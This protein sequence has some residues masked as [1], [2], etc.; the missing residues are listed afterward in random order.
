MLTPHGHSET[1]KNSENQQPREFENALEF[2]KQASS[3]IRRQL[4][5]NLFDLSSGWELFTMRPKIEIRLPKIDIIH[6]VPTEIALK[7]FKYL[8]ARSLVACNQVS[9]HWNSISYDSSLWH[10]KCHHDFPQKFNKYCI[11]CDALANRVAQM[12]LK[13]D[14]Q[15]W[16]NI[17]AEKYGIERNWK[18]G[19]FT[20][21]KFNDI[22]K[23]IYCFQVNEKLKRLVAGSFNSTI[24]AWDIETKKCINVFEGHTADVVWLQFDEFKIISGSHDDTVKIWDFKTFECIKTLRTSMGQV[25][26]VHFLDNILAAGCKDGIKVWNLKDYSSFELRDH[27][28]YVT[29]VQVVSSNLL[30]SSSWDKTVKLCNLNTRTVL[31]SIDVGSPV[32]HFKLLLSPVQLNP[33]EWTALPPGK[34]FTACYD[35][36]VKIF[37]SKSGDLLNTLI[38]HSDSV[39]CVDA[40]DSRIICACNE[41]DDDMY[42]ILNFLIL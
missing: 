7:V 19:N 9:K 20:T 3:E 5:L 16:K 15:L 4:L 10:P 17:Y 2:Y 33:N 13:E 35:K 38:G 29:C 32:L 25:W 22:A 21:R 8:D 31:Q 23:S 37:D 27:T 40:D 12:T 28:D 18:N 30:L 11:K 42:S 14:D 1:L 6:R 41:T 24:H 26:F 36:S 34:L 39:Q